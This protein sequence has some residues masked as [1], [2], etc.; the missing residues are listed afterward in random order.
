MDGWIGKILRVNLTDGEVATEELEP[1]LAKD[2]IGGRGLAEKILFD[3]IDPQVDPL[4]PENKMVFASGV[5]TGTGAVTGSRLAVVTKSPLTGTIHCS[6][7]GGYFGAELKFA[8]YDVIIFEGESEEPV[9][10]WINDD[11]VEIRSALDLWGKTSDETEDLIRAEIENPW[12]GRE[13]FIACI[14]PAGEKM[15]KL[16]SIIVEKHR[17]AGRSGVGAVMGS[18]NLKAVVVGGSKGITIADAEG[19]REAGL[20]SLEK[21]KKNEFV[22]MMGALGTLGCLEL[23]NEF[24]TCPS[25][26][27]QSGFFEGA[28][29]IGGEALKEKYLIK[30]RSCFACA[31]PCTR[32]TEVVDPVFGGRGGGPEYES[33]C[34]LGSICGIDNLAAIVK[35]NHLCNELGM[36]TIA[37]GNVIGCAM[38]LFEKGFLPEED[39]GFKLNFGN[40][41]GMVELVK[42][43][44]LREGFGD[45]LAE[46]GHHLAERYGH[47]EVFLGVKKLEAPAWDPRSVQSKGLGLA[48]CNF[49][50]NHSKEYAHLSEMFGIPVKVE[51]SDIEGKIYW[52][53]RWQEL[54]TLC[55]CTGLCA[56]MSLPLREE[57]MLALLETATGAG[58]TMESMCLASERVW[59]LEKL[60]NIRAG[61]T[62][63]DDT[64][65]KRFLEEPQTGG[66]AKGQVVDLA[67]MLSGYYKLRGWDEDGNPTEEK[68]A[69][70]GLK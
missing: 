8:G 24:G 7:V 31:I 39:V 63:A 32:V 58:Y 27:F 43:I 51:P 14:G 36:D 65:P 70:L 38:E 49:G 11:E 22:Q 9:Y 54:L 23:W 60:F 12:E 57:D 59:N 26:N 5:L 53:K 30:T 1:D 56:F 44:G 37:V 10:L 64:L 47:P 15:V 33:T 21:V 35:A 18:K 13:I 67:P 28:K 29:K 16:A 52:V 61:F 45:I 40:A 48:T 3:E 20:S 2:F 25:R 66:P 42:K 34:M 41:E 17:A 4:S 46:G 68:L 62:R 19:F 69:E 55:D 50:A 6:V